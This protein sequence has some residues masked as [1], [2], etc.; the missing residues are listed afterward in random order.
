MRLLIN[1]MFQLAAKIFV[2]P[3]RMRVSSVKDDKL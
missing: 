3:A 2:I 1:N